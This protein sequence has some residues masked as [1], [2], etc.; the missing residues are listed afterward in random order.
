MAIYQIVLM[1]LASFR[2]AFAHWSWLVLRLHHGSTEQWTRAARRRLSAVSPSTTLNLAFRWLSPAH[3]DV[4]GVWSTKKIAATLWEVSLTSALCTNHR[5]L[6]SSRTIT[7]T[8]T[9][10]R[11][12]QS[13]R[14]AI[15]QLGKG[16]SCLARTSWRSI[17]V[18]PGW[19]NSGLQRSIIVSDDLGAGFLPWFT[20][21]PSHD[22]K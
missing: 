7:G 18:G 2:M 8:R 16:D 3:R 10:T 22:V 6:P 1:G 17:L 4:A 19:L 11:R 20:A 9:R 15:K 12:K 13:L 14:S 5:W 21:W